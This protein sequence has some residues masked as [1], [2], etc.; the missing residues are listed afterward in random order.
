MSKPIKYVVNE[1]KRVIVAI[2]ED[3][4]EDAIWY[5]YKKRFFLD[6]F[7]FEPRMKMKKNYVGLARC[8]EEDEFD[9]KLGKELAKKR[10]LEKYYTD[11]LKAIDRMKRPIDE[12]FEKTM[13]KPRRHLQNIIKDRQELEDRM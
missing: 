1:K 9:V 6:V 4:E 11:F 10:V 8:C 13:S 3:T 2:M 12:H 5:M 7:P